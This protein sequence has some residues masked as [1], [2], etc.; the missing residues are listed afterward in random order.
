[1]SDRKTTRAA[2][3]VL[4]AARLLPAALPASAGELHAQAIGQPP[5]S[6]PPPAEPPAKQPEPQPRPA[7]PR[8]KP[9]EPQ[10][11]AAR[12]P[13]QPGRENLRTRILIGAGVALALGALGGGGNGGVETAPEHSP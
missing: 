4:L 8:A 7:E 11:P 6:R 3:A 1:M 13:E 10:P 12:R 2:V 5:E 9:P